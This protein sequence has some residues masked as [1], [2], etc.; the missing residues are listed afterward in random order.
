MLD[1]ETVQLRIQS[2]GC[3][4]TRV[5]IDSLTSSTAALPTHSGEGPPLGS[6]PSL[7]PPRSMDTDPMYTETVTVS[8]SREVHQ[9]SATEFEGVVYGDI[10]ASQHKNVQCIYLIVVEYFGYR[11]YFRGSNT[12]QLVI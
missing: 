3:G 4:H 2:S 12:L 9:Q 6:A 8:G 10:K 11:F 5:A 1:S 7:P